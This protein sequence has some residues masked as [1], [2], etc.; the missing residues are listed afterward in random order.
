ML[1]GEH[2]VVQVHRNRVR[3]FGAGRAHDNRSDVGDCGVA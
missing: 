2:P 3:G 1:E